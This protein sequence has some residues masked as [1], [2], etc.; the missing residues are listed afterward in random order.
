MI[1][2][3]TSKFPLIFAIKFYIKNFLILIS[4][5]ENSKASPNYIDCDLEDNALIKLSV[6][7]TKLG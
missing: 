4:Y 2:S 7:G 5:S 1:S 6:F 3:K